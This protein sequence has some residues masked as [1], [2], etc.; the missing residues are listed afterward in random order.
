MIAFRPRISSSLCS[1]SLDDPPGLKAPSIVAP[2]PLSAA[3][4][5]SRSRRSSDLVLST[6]PLKNSTS[7]LA[8][9][10]PLRASSKPSSSSCTSSSSCLSCCATLSTSSPRSCKSL[11]CCVNSSTLCSYIRLV[12]SLVRSKLSMV[13]RNCARWVSKSEVSIAILSFFSRT[14]ARNCDASNSS[15]PD[16]LDLIVPAELCLGVTNCNSATLLCISSKSAVCLSSCRSRASNS[17]LSCLISS[18][19]CSV[20]CGRCCSPCVL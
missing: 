3:A 4:A 10:S 11:I 15:M 18:S 16:P 5:F 20:G 8:S 17:A 19:L 7:P 12:S 6:S 2:A 13:F 14:K 9:A 1:T